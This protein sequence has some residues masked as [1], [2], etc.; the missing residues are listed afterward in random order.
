LALG[1]EAAA[2]EALNRLDE[3]LGKYQQ[4][5]DMLEKAGDKESL[6]VVLKSRSAL[7]VKSGKP[8]DALFSYQ[9][10]LANVEKP[11]LGQRILKKVLRLRP[12]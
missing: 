7:Q 3:A 9:S 12:W 10:S 6:A 2:L 1:N 5:A 8:I 11:S 4:S